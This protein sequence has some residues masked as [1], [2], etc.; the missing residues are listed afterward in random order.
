MLKAS[1][2]SLRPVH[3]KRKRA[4][5]HLQFLYLLYGS[6]LIVM[7]THTGERKVCQSC[8]ILTLRHPSSSIVV[9]AGTLTGYWMSRSCWKPM[10]I[11]RKSVRSCRVCSQHSMAMKVMSNRWHPSCACPIASTPNQSATTRWCRLWNGI[12]NAVTQ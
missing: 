9:V 4:V 3:E 1:D 2:F 8:S 12:Q 5:P 11:S 10:K 6:I 7:M